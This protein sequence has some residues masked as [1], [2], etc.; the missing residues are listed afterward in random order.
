MV[1]KAE[2]T[3][4]LGDLKPDFSWFFRYQD[5]WESSKSVL[6]ADLVLSTAEQSFSAADEYRGRNVVLYRQIDQPMVKP[7]RFLETILGEPLP[8]TSTS[9]ILWVRLNL[10]TGAN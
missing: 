4:D 5:D 6:Q 7:I 2:I 1:D 10:F 8:M 3:Y 9:G